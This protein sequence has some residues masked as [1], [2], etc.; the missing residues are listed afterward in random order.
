MTTAF[1]LTGNENNVVATHLEKGVLRISLTS[2]PANLMSLEMIDTLIATLKQARS[3]KSVR[4]ILL[5]A[6]GRIFSAGH[7]LK[8]IQVH[9][10]DSDGGRAFLEHL[11]RRCSDLMKLIVR[12]PKP[13]IAAVDGIA[14][15]A[16]CQLVA[17]CDLAVASTRAAFA[18]PGVSIGGFCSTPMVALSRNIS[19]KHALEM[20]LTGGEIDARTACRFGLVNRVVEPDELEYAAM[21]FALTIA[22][23][24]PAAVGMGK[25]GFYAQSEMRLSEAYDFANEIMID[26]FMSRDA[27]EGVGAFIEKRKPDWNDE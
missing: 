21:D 11:F 12:I 5:S 19:H 20:L 2:P 8:E 9:R 16:G 1:P 4:V 3:D 6:Q 17:S 25:R 24:S 18:T 13:V 26:G 14:S 10:G 23:K 27:D 7:D 15:A 22:G